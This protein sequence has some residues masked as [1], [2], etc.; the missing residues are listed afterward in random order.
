MK[1]FIRTLVLL[2]L[3]PALAPM[4]GTVS[5]VSANTELVP[6][7][8]LVVP[9]IDISSGRDTFL[10]LTN[11]SRFIRLDRTAFSVSTGTPAVTYANTLGLGVHLEFYDQTCARNDTTVDLTPQDINQLDF[12]VKPNLTGLLA[13]GTASSASSGVAG[14]GFID[15]DVRVT[16]AQL[17][18][19]SVQMNTLLGEVVISD[20]GSDFAFAYPAAASVGS[21][22]TGVAGFIVT[23][24]GGGVD[25]TW[26][27]RYEPFPPRVFVPAFFAEGTGT[28][29]AAGQVFSTFLA[30]AA[31]ADGNWSGDSCDAA[32]ACNAEAPGQALPTGTLEGAPII[33]ASGL[34][35]DGCEQQKSQNF[36]AHFVNNS[37]GSIFGTTNTDRQFWSAANCTN[38][39]FP[40]LDSFSGSPVGWV[41]I[42]NNATVPDPGTTAADLPRGVVG[43]FFENIIGGGPTGPHAG[44][45][46]SHVLHLGDAS[47]LWGDP[48]F[49]QL[50]N[51]NFANGGVAT[52]RYS[53]VD[54]VC[55][56]DTAPT[57]STFLTLAANG[58]KK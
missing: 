45:T 21:S 44:E 24:G 25:V 51:C 52:C 30:I 40:G 22:Q 13:G 23:R 27:G 54:T 39:I 10:L 38:K 55:H 18:D 9:L 46:V 19:P 8:R 4:L 15:I 58:C 12:L 11:V 35:F 3:L 28:G 36:S 16:P 26:T 33:N 34:L 1:L 48:S 6:A 57:P 14:R 41:D 50:A 49:I 29:S 43:V 42:S 31:P 5:S 2:M 53:L 47:R 56:I 20:F 32:G 17:T 37:L 7:S